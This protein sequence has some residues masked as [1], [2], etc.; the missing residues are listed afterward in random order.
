M[1]IFEYLKKRN[2][3][4]KI[5]TFYRNYDKLGFFGK[6]FW[7]IMFINWIPMVVSLV[8]LLSVGIAWNFIECGV[9]FYIAL[10]IVGL[11][12]I[13]W[14]LSGIVNSIKEYREVRPRY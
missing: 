11:V 14:V 13:P 6:A 4:G 5:G 9:L 10:G 1:L 7:G 12:F 2:P 3:K 8:F